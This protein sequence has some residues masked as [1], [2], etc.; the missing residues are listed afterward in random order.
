MKTLKFISIFC[1]F[2]VAINV[3]S[4]CQNDKK[5]DN[6]K[7]TDSKV[8]YSTWSATLSGGSMLFYGDL[9]QFDFYPLTKSNSKDWYKLTKG[10]TEWDRG[11]G[12][13]INKQLSPVF[14]IQGMLENGGLDGM[15]IKDDARFSAHFFTYGLNV[16]VNILPIIDPSLKSPKFDVYGIIGIGLC[17]FKTHENS[18]S[19]GAELMSY[20]YGEFGGKK[21][22]TTETNVPIGAGIKYKINNNFDIGLECTLNN[23]N[24]DKLDARV[25]ENTAKDKYQYTAITVTY[26]FGKNKPLEWTAPKDQ[27]S[28][29]L[30]PLFAAMDK[31]IDSLGKKLAETDNIT[32]QIQKD[33]TALMNPAKE[34]DDDGDGV[35]NSRDLEPNTPKGS[36]VDANGRAIT[37]AGLGGN[38]QLAS[39]EAQPQFSIF[40]TVNSSDIDELNLEKAFAAAEMLKANNNLDFDIIGHTDKSGAEEYNEYLSKKRAQAVYDLLVKEYGIEPSRLN[41]IAKGDKE[42]LSQNILSVNRRVDFI[43]R[44]SNNN[45]LPV[46]NQMQT[47]DNTTKYIPVTP[48]ATTTITNSQT[49]N[50]ISTNVIKDTASNISKTNTSINTNSTITTGHNFFIIAGSFPSEEEA[51]NAVKDLKSKG[52]PGAEIVGKNSYGLLRI[53]YNSYSTKEDALQDLYGIRKNYCPTAWIFERK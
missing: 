52:F 6:T 12:L 28:D 7:T 8:K 29:K 2:L 40:F 13:A 10:F 24:T 22:M 19:T 3:V 9:R 25:I 51:E 33:V 18:I 35:P 53:C 21:K 44:T 17:K 37:L 39:S 15:R 27:E 5:T 32:T 43:S 14:G 50:S 48:V 38:N 20:G 1:F 41:I 16:K 47:N 30:A 42:P 26:S 23:V 49:N 34:A 36:I 46:S 45:T 4:Y 31:K 11:F